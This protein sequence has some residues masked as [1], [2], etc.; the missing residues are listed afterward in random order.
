MKI[1]GYGELESVRKTV[2][3]DDRGK[4]APGAPPAAGDAS[5]SRDDTVSISSEAKTR[6]EAARLAGRIEQIPDLRRDKIEEALREIN[7]GTLMTPE[8]VK[9]SIAR[10]MKG[11]IL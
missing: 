4:K 1:G 10:M 6:A 7:D 3:K 8:N 5:V 2:Q 9:E 11:M